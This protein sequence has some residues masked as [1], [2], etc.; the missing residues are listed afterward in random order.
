MGAGMFIHH[1]TKASTLPLILASGK[2]R[3]TRADLLDDASE[4]PF[5]TAH[6][7]P[8]HYF[9]SSWT[10]ADKEQWTVASGSVSHHLLFHLIFSTALFP[11]VDPMASD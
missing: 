9:I 8:Q 2:I 10:N 4:M 6:L 5:E 7:L 3:F 11:T 1:Y